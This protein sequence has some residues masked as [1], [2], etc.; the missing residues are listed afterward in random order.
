MN[1]RVGIGF[2]LQS[3]GILLSEKTINTL[4]DNKIYPSVSYDGMKSQYI[5]CPDDKINNIIRENMKKL[6]TKEKGISSISVISNDNIDELIN[7]Y[8]EI[9]SYGATGISFNNIFPSTIKGIN[10]KDIEKFSQ[11]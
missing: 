8:E 5:R 11:K 3:N 7:I 1:P 10:P 6:L 2:G 9:K 4:V